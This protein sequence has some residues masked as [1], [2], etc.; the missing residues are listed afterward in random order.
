MD[1]NRDNDI[2]LLIQKMK[3]D[4]EKFRRRSGSF[5]NLSPDESDEDSIIQSKYKEKEDNMNNKPDQKDQKKLS[6]KENKTK[7]KKIKPDTKKENK[8]EKRKPD[9]DP[10]KAK[11][12]K[13]DKK[14]KKTKP[15]ANL[16]TEKRISKSPSVSSKHRTQTNP[17]P[18]TAISCSTGPVFFKKSDK[19]QHFKSWEAI[20]STSNFIHT[21]RPDNREGRKLNLISRFKKKAFEPKKKADPIKLLKNDFIPPNEKRRDDLRFNTRMKMLSF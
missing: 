15:E 16:L 1:K 21:N 5:K 12:D 11:K 2:D 17:R 19:L 6:P 3:Q 20:W 13:K 4:N 18:K 14:D 9:K 8:C 7:K 10:K